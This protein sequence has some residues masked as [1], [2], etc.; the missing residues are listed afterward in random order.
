MS[1]E[2]EPYSAVYNLA[3][4]DVMTAL[5]EY[6]ITY[7][8]VEQFKYEYYDVYGLY[9]GN[10]LDIGDGYLNGHI[11]LPAV[12]Q[13][14]TYRLTATGYTRMGDLASHLY[15]YTDYPNSEAVTS[16]RFGKSDEYDILHTFTTE[17]TLSAGGKVT[18][19]AGKPYDEMEDEFGIVILQKVTLEQLETETTIFETTV[20]ATDCRYTITGL[21]P[22]T[23]YTC[24][25]LPIY[26]TTEGETA[27]LLQLHT[28]PCLTTNPLPDAEIAY[29]D[30]ALT[31][32]MTVSFDKEIASYDE[33]AV[34]ITLRNR[35]EET[36]STISETTATNEITTGVEMSMGADGTSVVFHAESPNEYLQ[37]GWTCTV[38]F[39]EGA[40]SFIDGTASKSFTYS[41]NMSN[42]PTGIVATPQQDLFY[43]NG[44][45][46]T[47]EPGEPIKVYDLSG[48]KI[49]ESSGQLNITTLPK[50]IFLIHCRESVLKVVR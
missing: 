43:S 44:I 26:G 40:V 48:R 38:T 28:L 41:F 15:V 27:T 30:V 21:S 5:E 39:S 42:Y 49:A 35:N 11:T 25:V 16:G 19:E 17:L 18:L 2:S 34:S 13:A 33:G 8:N 3:K 50:G 22:D 1:T 29:T 36:I 23:D 47:Q 4:T 24:T 7:D 6:G 9:M 32:K 20:D 12:N 10:K 45:I 31:G 46:Q 14:G 37:P